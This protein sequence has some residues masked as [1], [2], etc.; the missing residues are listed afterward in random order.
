MRGRRSL[1]RRTRSRTSTS[2][3]THTHTHARARTH[4]RTHTHTHARARARTHART[5]MH[6]HTHKGGGEGW[7]RWKAIHAAGAGQGQTKWSNKVVKQSGQTK[8]SNK[9][10]KQ[11]G[12]TK[13]ST[14]HWRRAHARARDIEFNLEPPSLSLPLRLGFELNVVEMVGGG[15]REGGREV[16]RCV[17]P[18]GWVGRREGEREGGRG[19][20]AGGGE[21]AR[22]DA[23]ELYV[24][25]IYIVY[26]NIIY[27]NILWLYNAG[28][29][30]PLC[31]KLNV[32]SM[33]IIIYYINIL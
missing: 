27:F 22:E 4:A 10:V 25:I 23:G 8:W 12:Q 31:S 11:S 29:R 18:K 30:Q 6:T 2:R 9:A 1:T 5:H 20:G 33:Y 24:F 19:T 32:L 3:H 26:N 28:E 14:A 21:R 7:G 16:R 15:G 13:W 17:P